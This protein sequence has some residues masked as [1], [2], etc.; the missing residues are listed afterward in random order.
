HIVCELQ[1]IFRPIPL[2]GLQGVW[3]STKFL[4][5]VMKLDLVPVHG[6]DFDKVTGMHVVKCSTRA[7]GTP[8][9]DVIPLSQL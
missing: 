2:R 5:Y 8:M 6:R 1:L 4:A 9:G 7:C 3:W